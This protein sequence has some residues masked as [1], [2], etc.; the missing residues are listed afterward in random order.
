MLVE[1]YERLFDPATTQRI[2]SGDSTGLRSG[3]MLLLIS[4][5]IEQTAQHTALWHFGWGEVS[6]GETYLTHARREVAWEP[7]LPSGRLHLHLRSVAPLAAARWFREVLG[8]RVELA[9]SHERAGGTLP[10][11][12][13]RIPEAL[14]WIGETGLLIYRTEP[15][16]VSSRGQRA[17][18]VAIAC[19][20]LE[21]TLVEL[22]RRG[23]R[24]LGEP[25][26]VGDLRAAMIEGPDRLAIELVEVR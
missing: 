17:D 8:A 18:H 22:R 6:L 16:L 25:A 12:E 4:P 9:K 24:V 15:P 1:F 11:P 20:D 19:A 7:P 21:R 23:V 14:V 10:P 26:S 2:A 5:A 3:P 13:H